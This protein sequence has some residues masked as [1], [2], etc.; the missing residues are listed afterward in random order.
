MVHLRRAY[1]LIHHWGRNFYHNMLEVLPQFLNL[2]A[3]LKEDPGL[4]ILMK[5]N[6][7]RPFCLEEPLTPPFP[8]LCH[9]TQSNV[10]IHMGHCADHPHARPRMLLSPSKTPLSPLSWPLSLCGV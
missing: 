1:S 6:H 10:T 8:R 3:F 5:P 2:A 7:V 9:L 4:P